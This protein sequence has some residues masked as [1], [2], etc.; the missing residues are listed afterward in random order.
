MRPSRRRGAALVPLA[1]VL[2]AAP[3]RPRSGTPHRVG[4]A[5]RP[6]PPGDDVEA[7]APDPRI[8]RA[9][10]ERVTVRF[11][12]AACAGN[13]DAEPTRATPACGP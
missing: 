3:L 8:D 11:K 12:A 2:L 13:A 10:T 9:A 4:P 7:P 6:V 5:C 1:V